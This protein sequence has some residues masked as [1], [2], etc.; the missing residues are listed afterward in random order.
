MLEPA[1]TALAAFPHPR[2]PVLKV[3]DLRVT[4]RVPDGV[5]K[6]VDGVT[7][8][9]A[10]GETF[11]LVG[12]SGCGKSTIARA[13]MRLT[14]CETGSIELCGVDITRLS[15]RHLKPHRRHMQMVFQ[16]PYSSLNPR[17]RA[18]D[19]VGEPLRNYGASR[20]QRDAVVESLFRR[21][22]LPGEAMQRYPH[23]FSGGQRQR[24][25]IARALALHPSLIVADEPVSALDVSVQAQVLNLMRSIQREMGLAF[26]FISH[27]MAVVEHVSDRVAVMYLGKIVE[28]ADKK[29]IFAEPL[30]PYTQVLLNSVPVPDPAAPRRQRSVAGEIPSPLNPP[31]GCHFHTRCP[32]AIEVCRERA[33]ELRSISDGRSVACHRVETGDHSPQA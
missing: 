29:L 8:E 10:S 32:F 19:I 17:I 11:A 1:V 4:F 26:L 3:E 9:I 27:D 25:G 18:G 20:S 2:K 30:H 5:L 33:P 14:D 16:D 31:K 13:L 22:G 15:R 23:E 6:A 24:L 28:V 12:E 7:F 21:V